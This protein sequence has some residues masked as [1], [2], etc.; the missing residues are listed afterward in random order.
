MARFSCE[1]FQKGMVRS[2]GGP[3]EDFFADLI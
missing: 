1:S 3:D 2:V